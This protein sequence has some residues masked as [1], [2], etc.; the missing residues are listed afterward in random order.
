MALD[1][2]EYTENNSRIFANRVGLQNMTLAVFSGYS[3]ESSAMSLQTAI[4]VCPACAAEG[5]D[6]RDLNAC[7]PH[8]D[9]DDAGARRDA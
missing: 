8:R 1:A 7:A 2:L 9:D 6:S 4:D 3:S 5:N